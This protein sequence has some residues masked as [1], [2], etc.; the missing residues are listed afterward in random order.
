MRNFCQIDFFTGTLDFGTG[1]GVEST[2]RKENLSSFTVI[3]EKKSL[4]AIN[5]FLES[6]N[7]RLFFPWRQNETC[8]SFFCQMIMARYLYL[9]KPHH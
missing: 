4:T 9:T 1:I 2:L 7:K 8:D 5:S 3:I 6:Y